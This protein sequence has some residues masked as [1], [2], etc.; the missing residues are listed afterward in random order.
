MRATHPLEFIKLLLNLPCSSKCLMS[1]Y[2]DLQGDC[3]TLPTMQAPT[4]LLLHVA[5]LDLS[6][7]SSILSELLVL[8]SVAEASQT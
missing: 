3:L 7:A 8:P 4:H 1:G 5:G 2:Q 6:C